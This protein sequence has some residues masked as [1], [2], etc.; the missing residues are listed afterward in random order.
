MKCEVC[1][2]QGWV[3]ENH[4]KNAWNGKRCCGGAGMP[5]ECNSGEPPWV[6]WEE[7]V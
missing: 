1:K 4:P 7:T 6:N 2:D 5:C 3:C